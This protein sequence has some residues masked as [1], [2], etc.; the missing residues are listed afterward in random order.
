MQMELTANTWD[1][2]IR[3]PSSKSMGHRHLICAALSRGTSTVQGVSPSQDIEATL[4][5]LSVGGADTYGY[6]RYPLYVYGD[7]RHAL[8]RRH[9]SL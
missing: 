4:R 9:G 5:I 2:E 6:G 3:V 1:G 7:R 8:F